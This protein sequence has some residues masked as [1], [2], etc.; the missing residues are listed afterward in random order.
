MDEYRGPSPLRCS[1]WARSL[2]SWGGLASSNWRRDC[3]KPTLL[4]GAVT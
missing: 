4:S 1:N 3:L 2:S